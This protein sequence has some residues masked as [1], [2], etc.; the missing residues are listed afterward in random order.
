M[1]VLVH[2]S[3]LRY[4]VIQASSSKDRPERVV[5]SYRDE[6]CLRDLIAAPSIFGLGFASREEA[7]ANLE[8]PISQAVASNSGPRI[9]AVFYETDERGGAVDGHVLVKHRSLHRMLHS[10]FAAVIV[11]FYSKNPV[12]T[13]IRMALGASL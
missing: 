12:S 13:L 9:G 8:G 1:G 3:T 5:I 2:C 4:A 6:T 7:M 10:A 11:L